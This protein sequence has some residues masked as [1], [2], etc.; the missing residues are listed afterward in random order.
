MAAMKAIALIA[1]CAA[2][3]GTVSAADFRVGEPGGAWD[4]STDYVRWASSNKFHPGDTLIFRFQRGEHNVL[5]V[6]EADYNS[7]NATSPIDTF[8]AGLTSIALDATGTR[9]FICGFPGHCTTTGTG[10]MKL[11]IDVLPGSSPP[12]PVPSTPSSPSSATVSSAATAGF[13]LFVILVAN[14]MI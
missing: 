2:V 10:G 14:L 4:L 11:K 7:C 13:G 5:E 12:S 8:S 6:S 1:V 3:L 9:Y